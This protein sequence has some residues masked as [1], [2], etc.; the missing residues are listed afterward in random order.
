MDDGNGGTSVRFPAA[1]SAT[2]RPQGRREI[3]DL[4]ARH[5]L[6]PRRHLGQHFLADPNVVDRIV[7]L[8]QLGP[9]GKAVEIGAGTGTLTRA[10]A[11]TGAAVVAYEIDERLAP[12]L[13]EVLA[14]TGVDLRI[15]DAA[16]VNLE[17]AL[18]G[19]GWVMVANLPYHLGTPLLLDVLRDV[20]KVEKAVVMVQREVAER[21]AAGPGSRRYGLPSVV[22]GLYSEVEMG[23][24]VG[25]AVFVPPPD[26]ESAVVV[27][28]RRVAS[29]LAGRAEVLAQ[30]AFGQRRKMLRSSLAAAVADPEALVEA[31]GLDPT[32]RAETL[33]VDDYLRLAE[34]VP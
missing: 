17:E 28:R 32:A 13:A 18:D 27:V 22:A 6:R 21:L 25:R 33:S 24:T 5:G 4:L 29:P 16:G 10:L 12:L 34:S 7:R 30:A 31:A 9:A 20:P 26:V 8:A 14:G 11:A 23:F 15:A 19:T 3:V 1:V 2:P